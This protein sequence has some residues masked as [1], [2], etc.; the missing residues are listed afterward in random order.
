LYQGGEFTS[1]RNLSKLFGVS[2]PRITLFL[3]NMEKVGLI[4]R[5][6]DEGDKRL[7]K[8]IITQKGK[9]VLAWH[10]CRK[11][12]YQNIMNE[13]ITD[14]E[15]QFHTKITMKMV[16]NIL[17]ISERQLNNMPSFEEFSSESNDQYIPKIMTEEYQKSFMSMEHKVENT[18]KNPKSHK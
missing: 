4:S 10:W 2:P 12:M 15:L 14:E 3:D 18:R 16:D 8:I 11:K 5:I 6:S 17:N 7:N 13:G 1:Q 9:D